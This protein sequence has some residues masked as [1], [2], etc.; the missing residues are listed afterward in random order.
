MAECLCWLFVKTV[1][2]IL[3]NILMAYVR[4]CPVPTNMDF[5]AWE[6]GKWLYVNFTFSKRWRLGVS[7]FIN[8]VGAFLIK[9]SASMSIYIKLKLKALTR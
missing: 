7:S 1:R 8:T 5:L 6:L 2:H 9:T 4:F 3:I